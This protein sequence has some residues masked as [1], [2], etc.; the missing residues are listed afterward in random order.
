MYL[1]CLALHFKRLNEVRL[2]LFEEDSLY[3]T[4]LFQFQYSY[5]ISFKWMTS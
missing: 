3:V 5:K 1:I 2:K 4:P